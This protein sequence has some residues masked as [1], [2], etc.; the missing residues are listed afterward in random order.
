MYQTHQRQI[1]LWAN[2][3]PENT[4][5]VISF[6]MAT[7]NKK[8]AMVPRYLARYDKGEE[9]TGLSFMQ[10]DSLSKLWQGRR[11]V[12]KTI[13]GKKHD[14][15]DLMHYLV[16]I[17]GLGVAK[18]GFTAQLL[19]GTVGCFDVWNMKDPAILAMLD[20]D[21]AKGFDKNLLR[22][23]SKTP[24]STVMRKL[25]T[26]VGMCAQLGSAF[27]W[28]NWCATLASQYKPNNQ[29]YPWRTAYDVSQFHVDTCIR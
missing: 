18:A 2:G 12:Y 20:I 26:Y 7:A 4:H 21:L 3:S 27:L 6:V 13:Q 10:S 14:S 28:D 11:M 9:K 17:P 16:S 24:E 15:V 1:E 8:F 29:F 5:K 25:T 22:L 23:D 19:T